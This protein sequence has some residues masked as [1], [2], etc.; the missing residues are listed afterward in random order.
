VARPHILFLQSQTLPWTGRLADLRPGTRCRTLSEDDTTGAL[1]LIAHYPP[2]FAL[3]GEHALAAGEEWFVLDGELE[4]DGLRY[5]FHD[6]AFLPAGLPRQRL[7]SRDGAVVL[8]MFDAAPQPAAAGTRDADDARLIRRIASFDLS[9]KTGAEGS[10]TGKPLGPGLAVKHLRR[11]EATGEQTFLYACLP[12]HPPPPVMVGRFTHPMIEEI[13]TLS[14]E[15][16]FGDAGVMREGGYCWWREGEWHGPAG[17]RFGYCLFIR[18]IG[19]ALRNQFATE[20]APFSYDAAYRPAL[21]A[22]LASGAA[23]LPRWPERW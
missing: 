21:P 9:W 1:T 5:G 17:S 13:F 22:G 3:E 11:D 14:G 2:G 20:P 6:Y 23:S 10:V 4:L 15:Y 19:G 16:V 8:T 7:T 12:H 18:V